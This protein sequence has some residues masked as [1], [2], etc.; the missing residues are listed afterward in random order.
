MSDDPPP[1]KLRDTITYLEM[2]AQPTRPPPPAPMRPLALLRANKPTVSFYRYLYNTVGEPW[3]W[4]ERRALSDPALAAIIQ[5]PKVEIFVL[6]ADG[7]PAG[8]FEL[9]RR[10]P[11]EVELSFFGLIPE[12]I[13][14]GLGRYLLGCAVATAWSGKP[15]RFWLHTCGYDHPR[16]LG[17]YQRAG[18]VPYR[19]ETRFFDDPYLSGLMPPRRSG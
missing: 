16:A 17:Y 19:Q 10:V 18:F 11:S 3:M 1:G 2:L 8:Y 12:F 4:H 6:Y 7:V 13:G 5:D 15:S 9:D 14:L